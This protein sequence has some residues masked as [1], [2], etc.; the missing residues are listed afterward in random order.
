[1]A[2]A[3]DDVV[4]SP[5]RETR[6]VCLPARSFAWPRG[7]Q[8]AV[9]LDSGISAPR[10]ARAA[11]A[12]ALDAWGMAGLADD[13]MQ[14]AS[15][16]VA[17]AVAA[18]VRAAPEGAGSCPVTLIISSTDGEVCIRVWDPDPTP[19][20]RTRQ[21]PDTWAERGRGLLIVEELQRPVGLVPRP[22]RQV[23]VVCAPAQPAATHRMTRQACCADPRSP[24]VL[25]KKPCAYGPLSVVLPAVRSRGGSPAGP[26]A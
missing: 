24:N 4:T 17:N 13:A 9:V 10:R 6:P 26:A 20:P 25:A 21:D 11:V 3:A 7:R 14:V 5:G 18:S 12:E 16:L 1:M 2:V 8:R 22:H 19:L 23:R 15:E